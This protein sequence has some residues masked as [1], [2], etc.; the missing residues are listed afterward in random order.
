MLKGLDTAD[1]RN[2]RIWRAELFFLNLDLFYEVI[3]K[4]AIAY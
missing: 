4:Q 3:D 2:D 1:F